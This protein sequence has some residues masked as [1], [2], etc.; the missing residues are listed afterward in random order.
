[1]DNFNSEQ[2]K[3]LLDKNDKVGIAIGKNPQIDEMAAALSLYLCLIQSGKSVSIACPTE[4]TVEISSLVGINKVKTSFDGNTSDLIV[5]FPDRGDIEK[6]SYTREDGFIN[7]IVKASEQGLSFD[8]RDIE[9]KRNSGS[10][11]LIFIIGTPKLSDL[12]KIFDVE[13]L[14]DTTIINIDNK[15]NNQGF[16]DIV[17]VSKDFSS[18]SESVSL[19]MSSL[20]LKADIDIYANL[21]SG[22]SHA[23]SNFQDPKTS[24]LAF[25]MAAMLMKKGAR[26]E[27]AQDK[28]RSNENI[29]DIS[30][31]FPPKKQKQTEV[32]PKP[33]QTWTKSTQS[34]K[35][36][37]LT[38]PASQRGEQ[39]EDAK[40][41]DDDSNPPDD[42]L[43]P[44]IYKGSTA[45]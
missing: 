23:T 16:G 20:N 30:S 3:E 25:E 17:I 33:T 27:N 18:V 45:V 40:E 5:S 34:E 42:W 44:K 32:G 38:G 14:K 28:K 7:I 29:Q 37:S 9:Y 8:E 2:I 21:L 31:F 39:K 36:P 4:P 35:K 19:L 1:M 6:I 12:G 15:E 13:G 11:N 24:P 43:A 22:I 26:R 41:E 10:P